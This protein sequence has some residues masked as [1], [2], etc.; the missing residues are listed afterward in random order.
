[1]DIVVTAAVYLTKAV[2]YRSKVL[3]T[4]TPE[5]FYVRN[6]CRVAVS[7]S[8]HPGVNLLELFT[9]VIY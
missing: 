3:I 9:A 7:C 6:L 8:D 4:L 1:M 5:T 2:N